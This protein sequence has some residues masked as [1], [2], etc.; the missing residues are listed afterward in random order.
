AGFERG[1]RESAEVW[2]DADTY[3]VRGEQVTDLLASGPFRGLRILGGASDVPAALAGCPQAVSPGRLTIESDPPRRCLLPPEDVP[4]PASS[5]HLAG[6]R[7]LWLSVQTFGDKGAEALAGSVHLRNL[8]LLRLS[9]C[10]IGDPGAA[11]LASSAVLASVTHL[12]L[13]F[14]D[15]TSSG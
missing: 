3:P 6:L 8:S 12:N 13:R 14:N 9:S 5:P 7:E 11:A 4:A 1:F 2:F 10:S 15:I